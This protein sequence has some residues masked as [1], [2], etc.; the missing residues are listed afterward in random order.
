ML[1]KWYIPNKACNTRVIGIDLLHGL[2]YIDNNWRFVIMYKTCIFV[3][4]IYE[5]GGI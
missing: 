5:F 2:S 3:S 1:S 4:S